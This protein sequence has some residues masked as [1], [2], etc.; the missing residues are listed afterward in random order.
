[1]ALCIT[2]EDAFRCATNGTFARRMLACMIERQE[3]NFVRAAWSQTGQSP[4][5]HL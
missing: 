2:N 1:M 4:L 3:A 5:C